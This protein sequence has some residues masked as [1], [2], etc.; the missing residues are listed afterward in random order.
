M[1]EVEGLKVIHSPYDRV[2]LI[3]RVV[4]EGPGD[5][6]ALPIEEQMKIVPF[7]KWPR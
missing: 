6:Q 3:G 1:E 5:T 7:K 4:V 2:W